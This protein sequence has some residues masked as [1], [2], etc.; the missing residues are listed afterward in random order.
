VEMIGTIRTLDDDM[1]EKMFKDI[2]RTATMIASSQGATADVTINKGY[3][4]T[5]NDPQLTSLMLP[6]LEASAGKE[7]VILTNAKTGAEDF[8]FYQ[9]EV[10]GL[11]FFLGGMPKDMDPKDAF[12]HHTPDFFV[13]DE[14]MVLGIKA[15]CH[16]VIDYPNVK[17]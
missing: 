9:K 16:L 13:T 3:P 14:S 6:S 4:V 1:R 15:F 12:P 10:P 17:K 7:N 2:E 11:F 8:S 5:Y